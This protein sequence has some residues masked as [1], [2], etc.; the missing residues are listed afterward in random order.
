MF[1]YHLLSTEPTEDPTPLIR[2]LAVFLW[3]ELRSAGGKVLR[4]IDRL[5]PAD[6]EM[7]MRY[8]F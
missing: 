3:G 5:P 6:H 1:P 7:L 4:A 8:P 2:E